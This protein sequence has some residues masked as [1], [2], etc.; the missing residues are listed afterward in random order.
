MNTKKE[1]IKSIK[2]SRAKM[3]LIFSDGREVSAPIKW[4]P[5]L[6]KA[7]AKQLNNWEICGAGR[8]IHWPDLDEDLSIDGI[9]N[10]RPSFEY[11]SAKLSTKSTSTRL[12][13]ISHSVQSELRV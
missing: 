13:K 4:Y 9:L 5:R 6:L 7:T 3:T 10:G 1:S 8:G 11:Q 2:F 12:P